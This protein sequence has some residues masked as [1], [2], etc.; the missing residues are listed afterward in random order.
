MATVRLLVQLMLEV[1]GVPVL[2]RHPRSL[3]ST[4]A[5]EALRN[6]RGHVAHPEDLAVLLEP[7]KYPKPAQRAS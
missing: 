4:R 3:V 1:R 6:R 5:K 7:V 2:W